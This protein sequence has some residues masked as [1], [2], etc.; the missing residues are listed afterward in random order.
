MKKCG[1]NHRNAPEITEHATVLGLW[2]DNKENIKNPSEIIAFLTP[3]SK[4][5]LPLLDRNLLL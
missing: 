3:L 2:T 5:M 1:G 4:K